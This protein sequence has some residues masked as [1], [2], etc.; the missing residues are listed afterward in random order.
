MTA[1]HKHMKNQRGTIYCT[2]KLYFVPRRTSTNS[3]TSKASHLQGFAALLIWATR[4]HPPVGEYLDR[5]AHRTQKRNDDQNPQNLFH[6]AAP[7][8][9]IRTVITCNIA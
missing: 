5:H 4:R 8:R 2:Q 7:L 9:G 3:S 6:D 1:T